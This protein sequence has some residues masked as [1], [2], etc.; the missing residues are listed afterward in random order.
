MNPNLFGKNLLIYAQKRR[1]S[2][3]WKI[4]RIPLS[5]FQPVWFKTTDKYFRFIF[6]YS[7]R[8]TAQ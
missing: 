7:I 3:I 6:K 1:K 2:I 8:G 5:A 4:G